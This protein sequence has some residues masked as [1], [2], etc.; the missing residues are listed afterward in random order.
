MNLSER[1]IT[2][3]RTIEADLRQIYEL[4]SGEP[5]FKDL[6]FAF[7]AENL[8]EIFASENSICCTAVRKKKVLGFIAGYAADGVSRI[9][10]ITVKE[11][12]RKAGIG[13]ELLALYREISG[14][15]GARNFLIDVFKNS[16]GTVK[17]F[18]GRGFTVKEDY[19]ELYKKSE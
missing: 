5:C 6:T 7:N 18:T 3:R 11:T 2:V 17:F 15:R 1:G 13:N 4:G 19:V 9:R 10:W 14:I 8:A 12:F 16:P